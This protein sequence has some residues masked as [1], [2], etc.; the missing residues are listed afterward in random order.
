MRTREMWRECGPPA[1][2]AHTGSAD[3][4]FHFQDEETG[5]QEED[6]LVRMDPAGK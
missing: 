5:D 2:H 3:S 4:F 6:V 1:P